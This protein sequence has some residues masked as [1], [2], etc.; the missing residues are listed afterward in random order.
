MKL[1][2]SDQTANVIFF[3]FA[4]PIVLSAWVFTLAAAVCVGAFVLPQAVRGDGIAIVS[5]LSCLGVSWIGQGCI[6]SMSPIVISSC[7]LS[8]C[9]FGI[10][11]CTTWLVAIV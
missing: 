8:E 9:L 6:L 7:D 2:D 5:E 10:R 11:C 3:R 1:E 4:R